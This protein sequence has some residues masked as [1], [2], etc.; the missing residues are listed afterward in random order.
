MKSGSGDYAALDHPGVLSRL[1]HPRRATMPEAWFLDVE[2]FDIP[3]DGNGVTVGGAFFAAAPS[4]PV[5]LFF[6]GNGETVVDYADTGG[7]YTAM[8]IN[9]LAVDYRGYGWSGGSPTVSAMLADSRA[10]FRFA[11][12]WLGEKGYT[13]PWIVMG[14]SLGSA[15][16]LELAARH[17]TDINGLVIESGF[18]HTL[19][20]LRLLGVDVE[21]SG[22]T[23]S[24]GLG[25]LAKIAC[26]SK[27]LL[28]IHAASDHIIPLSEGK[29]LLDACPAPVKRMIRIDQADHNTIFYYGSEAY[30]SGIKEFVSTSISKQGMA[31]ETE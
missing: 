3:V 14:R 19:P 22:I 1:F 21:A 24:E 17:E 28:V 25:N 30:M 8:D 5:I 12:Q 29:A 15:C 6:H 13:G 7:L 20:L 31:G 4:A 18:A 10:A 9:F 27:P 23:E 11:R 2:T 16:A 26:W